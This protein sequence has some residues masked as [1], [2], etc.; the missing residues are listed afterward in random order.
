MDYAGVTKDPKKAL[1]LPKRAKNSV[2]QEVFCFFC[3]QKISD[4]GLFQSFQ[5]KDGIDFAPRIPIT[6]QFYKAVLTTSLRLAVQNL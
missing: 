4:R 3:V 5:I 6:D 1:R 2:D